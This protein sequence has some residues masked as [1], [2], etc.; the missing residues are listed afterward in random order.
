MDLFYRIAVTNIA[1]PP[2]R[3]RKDDIPALVTH[4]LGQLCERYGL[5]VASFDDDA[6]RCLLA[7]DWPGNIR[8]LRN[9]LEGSLLMA[10][11]GV[12]TMDKLPLEISAVGMPGAAGLPKGL[13]GSA[14][15][16]VYSLEMAE[17]E[18]IRKALAYSGGNLTRTASRLGIAKST[19]YQKI[20]KYGLSAALSETRGRVT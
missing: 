15:E 2:L 6:Y 10:E 19:L 7:Y 12:I 11:G 20:R 14:P 4:W 16:T 8:E 3:E 18:S 9:A 5:P 1:I 17:S 13:A